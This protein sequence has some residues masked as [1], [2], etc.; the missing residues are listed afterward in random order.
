M[1]PGIV[2]P[3]LLVAIVVPVALVWARRRFKE[4]GAV[5]DELPAAPAARLTSNALRALDSP[6]WRV[7]YEI[8]HERLGG[9]E[10]VLIGPAGIFAMVTSMDPLPRPITDPDARAVAAAAILRG[11]LDDAL[12]RCGMTSDRLI[13][14]YWGMN[15]VDAPSSV[16]ALP[17]T[18]AVDGRHVHDWA[19]GAAA[20]RD[21]PPLSPAQ[22]DLAWQT[23]VTAIGRPDPLA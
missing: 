15:E 12:R 5:A 22:V 18:T 4:G 20:G 9:V 21:G 10:H 6:P 16:E 3:V 8:G 19:A 14:M 7:V 13:N 23:V 2:I 11:A 17:G 1:G